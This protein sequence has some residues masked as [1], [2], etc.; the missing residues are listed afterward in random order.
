MRAIMHVNNERR[1]CQMDFKKLGIKIA[2]V[3]GAVGAVNWGL[4]QFLKLNLV[5]L[6]FGT[7]TIAQVVYAVVTVGGVLLLV[8]IFSKK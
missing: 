8:K 2:Q 3:S 7:G 5:E 4:V 1:D 6:I